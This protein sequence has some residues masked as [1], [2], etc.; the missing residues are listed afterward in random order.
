[1]A[2]KK[3]LDKVD[4]QPAPPRL[5]GARQIAGQWH[6]ANGTPLS[7][8][9]SQRAHRAQDAADAAARRKALLGGDR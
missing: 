9:D 2:P 5:A 8:A 1:M 3:D 6:D 7:N 4:A